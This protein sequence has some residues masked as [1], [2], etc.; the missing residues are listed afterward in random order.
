MRDF[1]CTLVLPDDE[2][3]TLESDILEHGAVVTLTKQ[4]ANT[5]DFVKVVSSN[6]RKLD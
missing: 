3:V 5:G 1:G 4:T 2:S 6:V